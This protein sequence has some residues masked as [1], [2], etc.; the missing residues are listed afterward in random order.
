MKRWFVLLVCTLLLGVWAFAGCSPAGLSPSGGG[1]TPPAGGD[2]NGGTPSDD[3]DDPDKPDTP[4]WTL[5]W[6]DEFEGTELDLSKWDY[7]LGVQD[8]Y[9]GTKGPWAW[10]NNEQQYYTKEAATVSE[11]I[12]RIRAIKESMPEGRKY[13]SARLVTRDK[14]SFTYGYTEARMQTPAINGMWPAFWALP[15]P[16]DHSSTQNKYGGWPYSGEIDIMEAKGREKNVVGTTL[17]FGGSAGSWQSTYRWHSTT[18]ET[19]TEEW[20]TY[21]L[22]WQEDYIAWY[23][24]REEVFRLNQADWWTGA[25]SKEEAPSAPFDVP[26]YLLLDLAV[27]GDYDGGAEPPQ[28]FVSADMCVDYVRVY[29][30][31]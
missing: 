21:G 4:A 1:E 10:G 22:E 8:D 16:I 29:Q 26:F 15:Q 14:Y 31:I 23:I 27:G 19:T 25:A 9:Y 6:G 5:V 28:N 2:G 20:H 3:P 24:D 13:S 18:L 30:F 17:H 11:G 7:Q 12:L